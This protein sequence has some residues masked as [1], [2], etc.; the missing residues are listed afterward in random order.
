MKFNSVIKLFEPITV[1]FRGTQRFEFGRL[2]GT[3]EK[4]LYLILTNSYFDTVLLR[5]FEIEALPQVSLV[6][7]FKIIIILLL[8]FATFCFSILLF[9]LVC[10]VFFSFVIIIFNYHHPFIFYFFKLSAVS[11]FSRTRDQEQIM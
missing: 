6:V 2:V 9:R 8:S 1:E 7:F 5:N 10:F 3:L 4:R 11:V